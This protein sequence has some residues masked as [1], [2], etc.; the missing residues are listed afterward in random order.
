M[1][2][3][4][5][6]SSGPGHAI[7]SAAFV[8]AGDGLPERGG[9]V[10]AVGRA[11][12]ALVHDGGRGGLAVVGD[13]DLHTAVLVGGFASRNFVGGWSVGI[14]GEG[15]HHVGV[16]NGR[17]AGSSV[18]VK[19]VDGH[20]S[21][22]VDLAAAGAASCG[23]RRGW[24]S[25]LGGGRG[26]GRNR[27]GSRWDGSGSRGDGSRSLR[28]RLRSLD[29]AWL[30]GSRSLGG[31]LGGSLSRSRLLGNLGRRR[32]GHWSHGR[33]GLHGRNWGLG[34]SRRGSVGGLAR[35]PLEEGGGGLSGRL[36]SVDGGVGDLGLDQSRSVGDIGALVEHGS[37][38]GHGAEEH[39][40]DDAGSLHVDGVGGLFDL[41]KSC[42]CVCVVKGGYES[43]S[44]SRKSGH[45]WAKWVVREGGWWIES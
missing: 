3:G 2:S 35:G 24:G 12:W 45:R 15:N 32:D 25:R 4:W 5:Y 36:V 42:V 14:G 17:A 26:R 27:S 18:T 30:G 41:L 33:R 10:E 1:V 9:E 40:G 31:R 8:G 13:V 22:A 28:G 21:A 37:G 20:G 23:S 19:G 39:R 34:G 44:N 29:G 16:G 7:E 6:L 11:A 43:T 38:G